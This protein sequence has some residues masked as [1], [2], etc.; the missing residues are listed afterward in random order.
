MYASATIHVN[1][2]LC[3]SIIKGLV[4]YLTVDIDK[5]WPKLRPDW[6]TV[7]GSGL[8]TTIPRYPIL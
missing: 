4:K 6:V 3:T 5:D 2:V 7:A 8:S 1:Y